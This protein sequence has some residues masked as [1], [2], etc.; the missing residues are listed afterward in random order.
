[1]SFMNILFILLVL[2]LLGFSVRA[3][4]RLRTARERAWDGSSAVPSPLSEAIMSLIGTAGG[5]YL[6][7]ELLFSF[8]EIS[9]PG[10]VELFSVAVEPVA[11]ACIAMAIVQPL[12]ANLLKLKK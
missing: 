11:A 7:V 5:L 10:R 8:L 1:M 2:A 12:F 9:V 4:V 3:R 6:S